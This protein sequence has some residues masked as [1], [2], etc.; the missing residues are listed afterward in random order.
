M[1]ANLL[2]NPF[3]PFAFL[4]AEHADQIRSASHIAAGVTGV[5]VWDV[6]CHLHDDYRLLFKLRTGLCT[7]VYFVSRLGSLLFLVP[8]MI[9]S[10]QPTGNCEIF[11]KICNSFFPI[12]VASSNLLFF[13]RLRAVCMENPTIIRIG[14][15][16][17]LVSLAGCLTVPFALDS[18]PVGNT[19]YCVN[20]DARPY[21]ALS[22]IFPFFHD[23]FVFLAIT[24]KLTKNTHKEIT[25]RTGV[26]VA[27]LGDYLPAFSR[28]LL[29]DGQRYYLVTIVTNFIAVFMIFMP[30]P[31]VYRLVWCFPNVALI[32]MMACLVYRN[33]KLGR[34]KG[35]PTATSDTNFNGTSEPPLAFRHS[36]TIH[37]NTQSRST[38][39]VNAIIKKEPLHGELSV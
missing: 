18:V 25:L 6:V 23:T 30:L 36:R 29:V 38:I 8:T 14:F 13:F 4:T 12:A 20:T 33:T 3:T 34:Y 37:D 21:V 19:K 32:N 35:S 5:L 11:Q 7:L 10:V 17:W 1:D 9:L 28:A 26:R 15:A 24:W 16:L 39:N 31:I 22:G 27:L 2:P